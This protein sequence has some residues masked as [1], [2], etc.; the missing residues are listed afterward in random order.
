[1]AS[2]PDLSRSELLCDGTYGEVRAAAIQDGSRPASDFYWHLTEKEQA[3]M[4]ALFS[5][6]CNDR[7]LRIASRELFK[8]VR[9]SVWEFKRSGS[10]KVRIFT[11]RHLNRWWLLSGVKKK[12]NDLEEA[13]IVRA[14][15][16]MG[17]AII[18]H[19]LT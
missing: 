1:M 2:T 6:I 5:S 7:T 9:G 8:L 3:S 11:F 17:E 13:D 4:Q 10:K 18:V 16:Q 14:L 12:E 19:R 15:N